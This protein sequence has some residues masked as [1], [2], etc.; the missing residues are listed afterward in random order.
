[1]NGAASPERTY[2]VTGRNSR[3]AIL[4]GLILTIMVLSLL[5]AA[6][7][8]QSVTQTHH[9]VGGNALDQAYYLAES[10]YRYAAAKL[11]SGTDLEILQDGSPY[12]LGGRNERFSLAFMPYVFEITGGIGSNTLEVKVPF[13][14][15]PDVPDVPGFLMIDDAVYAYASVVLPADEKA[16][17]F[18]N[19][20]AWTVGH[21]SRVRPALQA[22]VYSDLVAGG[23][24]PISGGSAAVF[25]ERNGRFTDGNNVYRYQR[26]DA[27][28]NQLA[29]VVCLDESSGWDECATWQA[30]AA[31]MISL[32]PH[33]QLSATGEVGS[34]SLAVR[35]TIRYEIP[36]SVSGWNEFFDSFQDRSHWAGAS[37][38]GGHDIQSVDDDTVLRVT[39]VAT[40]IGSPM[41]KK[42]LIALNPDTTGVGIDDSYRAAGKFLSYDAQVKIGFAGSPAPTWG[43]L[44]ADPAIPRFFAAGLSLRL[45]NNENFYGVSFM[46]GNQNILEPLDNIDNAIVPVADVPLVVLWQQTG[47]GADRT[48]LA[49]KQ[50]TP[51][52]FFADDMES[53]TALWATGKSDASTSN[54]WGQVNTQFNSADT[55]WHTGSGGNYQNNQDTWIVSAPID[56]SWERDVVL[57]F[58]HRYRMETGWD[59][60]VVEISRDNFNT[61]ELLVFFTGLSPWT[62]HEVTIPSDY[63]T[64]GVRIR[65]R[66][67]TDHSFTYEGW[68]IDDVILK[69]DYYPLNEATLSVR[70][71][72]T[73]AIEFMNGSGLQIKPGDLV[74][75]SATGAYGRVSGDPIVT[76][77]IWGDVGDP[78]RGILLLNRLNPLNTFDAGP[79]QVNGIAVADAVAGTYRPKDN[80]IQVYYGDK[81][82]YG[83]PDADLLN[84]ERH[85]YPR[86]TAASGCD[87][88]KWPPDNVSL[89][90]PENDY[91]TLVQW[92]GVNSSV[93][94]AAIVNTVNAPG[95]IIRSN[96]AALLSPAMWAS[97][98]EIGLHAYGHG[99]INVYYDD[100][101]LR[102]ERPTYTGFLP[103]VQQ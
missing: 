17:R 84:M 8:S 46:R 71:R 91:F 53:G 30:P 44:P 58:W 38:Y 81:N 48:W 85:G 68:Y 32:L 66:L 61:Y 21:R 24:L 34:G 83:T 57:Q 16:V 15:R 52:I 65:F 69:S 1:M 28:N 3:G 103:A 42:S 96:E 7:L 62:L 89:A 40:D 31:G 26:A 98:P 101:G 45:D 5:G 64:T 54:Q 55:S 82:G 63:L 49:Y 97:R 67:L 10:G 25:P 74:T 99:A 73:A 14:T 19:P 9:L 93:A 79:L 18:V 60:G 90:A 70:L 36:L 27:V 6:M 37:A 2:D 94:S 59:Y 4:I 13:G 78:A 47:N 23:N 80:Y 22:G 50:L 92:D 95:S 12:D 88:L 43:F 56:L 76:G 35:H 86:C 51:V 41:P 11:N 72:E 87:A 75:Q 100:F 77:G 39:D 33:L 29:G 102:S 20:A